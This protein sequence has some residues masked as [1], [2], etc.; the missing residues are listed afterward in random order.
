MEPIF[1]NKHIYMT[2]LIQNLIPLQIRETSKRN[3]KS[4][5]EEKCDLVTNV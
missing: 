5:E 1:V 3:T 2:V 4:E